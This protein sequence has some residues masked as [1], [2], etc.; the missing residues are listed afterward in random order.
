MANKIFI[1][2]S[3]YIPWKGFFDAMNTVDT[4]VVYD[5]MQFTRRDWRNRNLIK[6]KKGLIWLTIPVESK[7]K[8]F[9]K[10]N[11]VKIADANWNKKHWQILKQHYSSAQ[12][13]NEMKSFIEELYLG[14]NFEYLSEIN[15][16]FLKRI[17]EFLKIKTSIINNIQTDFSVEKNERLIKICEQF[18]ATEYYTGS[19]AKAYLDESKFNSKAID[20]HYFDYKNYPEH[21]QLF[22]PFNHQVSIID[23]LF[24]EGGHSN[25]FMKSFL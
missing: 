11:E 13:F 3:N 16:H 19:A 2:Q 1:S 20:V 5:T 17:N 18:N 7:G 8:Y 14:C 6:T 23:L 9:Q 22:E 12:C 24:N 15:L 10:I 4:F 21:H 25:K